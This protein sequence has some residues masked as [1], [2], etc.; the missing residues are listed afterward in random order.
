[1]KSLEVWNC[2]AKIQRR[3]DENGTERNADMIIRKLFKRSYIFFVKTDRR[4][5]VV[6]HLVGSQFMRK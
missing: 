1:M 3:T 2:E 6:S 5:G 4:G